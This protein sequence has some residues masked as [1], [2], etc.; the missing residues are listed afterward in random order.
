MA[1]QEFQSRL[2]FGDMYSVRY[3]VGRRE[4]HGPRATAPNM[5][6]RPVTC[7]IPDAP[8]GPSAPA[9]SLR[10][11]YAVKEYGVTSTNFQDSIYHPLGQFCTI[12]DGRSFYFR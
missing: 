10:S 2:Q 11:T 8:G 1:G 3:R 6:Q 7:I 9:P 4:T 5:A 12:R